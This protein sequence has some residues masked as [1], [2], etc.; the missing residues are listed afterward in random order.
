M[1]DAIQIEADASED[2]K[3]ALRELE[4]MREQVTLALNGGQYEKQDAKSR[5]VEFA[6]KLKNGVGY[7]AQV[8]TDVAAIRE[9]LPGV[10]T[11]IAAFVGKIV[12]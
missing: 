10:L 7:V 1:I 5:L 9:R 3:K 2:R 12:P 8:T 4:L 6:E 11:A